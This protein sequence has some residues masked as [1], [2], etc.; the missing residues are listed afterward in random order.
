[1][2]AKPHGE[3]PYKGF[4]DLRRMGAKPHAEPHMDSLPEDIKLLIYNSVANFKTRA[5]LRCTSKAFRAFELTGIDE[6]IKN[7]HRLL[8]S[9]QKSK[10]V[11]TPDSIIIT[12]PVNACKSYTLMR[13]T[14]FMG[15]LWEVMFTNVQYDLG[16][17]EYS[18]IGGHQGQMPASGVLQVKYTI[19]YSRP[20]CAVEAKYLGDVSMEPVVVSLL[21]ATNQ[22]SG[23]EWKMK[24]PDNEWQWNAQT[25]W[26]GVH[27]SSIWIF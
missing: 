8:Y 12:I 20:R 5:Y 22:W 19:R 16:D 26:M 11:C 4:L 24:L 9:G 14:C 21:R 1:M 13:N 27:I 6:H 3:T 7:V 17:E 18:V 2:G 15:P 25:S 10:S 23:H